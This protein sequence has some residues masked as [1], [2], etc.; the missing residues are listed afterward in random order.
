[1]PGADGLPP[2]SYARQVATPISPIDRADGEVRGG[3]GAAPPTSL[4]TQGDLLPNGDGVP[5][6][7]AVKAPRPRPPHR[8]R[9]GRP[10]RDGWRGWIA[11]VAASLRSFG[12]EE[13]AQN[14]TSCGQT[15]R[16]TP[17]RDVADGGCG[18]PYGRVEVRISCDARVCPWCSRRAAQ[19]RVELV[20]AAAMRVPDYQAAQ[21]AA[22]VE[23]L[24]E[25]EHQAQRA[26]AHW[27]AF[28]V[29]AA[30]RAERR[31]SQRERER[32]EAKARRHRERAEKAGRRVQLAR[33]Q[34]AGVRELHRWGWKLVTISPLWNPADA[35][36]Y[37][38]A[39]M[40]ARAEDVLRRWSK[41]WEAGARAG[42]LA[43]AT[44]RTEMSAHGHIHVHVLYR[45]PWVPQEWWQSEAGCIVDVRAIRAKDAR[46]V[47]RE[48]KR[49]EESAAAYA[50]RV[51]RGAVTEAVKYALKTPTPTSAEWMSGD[52]RDVAHPEL[53][54]RWMLAT[55]HMQLIRHYGVMADAIAAEVEMQEPPEERPA[56]SRCASCG[57]ELHTEASTM[58]PTARVARALGA[59]WK[60]P[61]KVSP[62][63][64]PLPKRVQIVRVI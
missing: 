22:T 7:G 6:S 8:H 3:W 9:L 23:R 61:P 28:A 5:A 19:E 2:S 30:N 13:M 43:A 42:G 26:V 60:A 39:T 4:D 24:Q 45:G 33:R 49:A 46:G 21:L 41:V 55:R 47:E 20:T 38:P 16:V 34:L 27:A 15:A 1:M 62:W 12:A 63:G 18:D 10:V 32:D 37:E 54:A 25:Q 50:E 14:L 53:A 52:R 56:D 59:A 29:E 51:L 17:C 31:H 57:G 40:R 58:H 36:E 48:A 11:R 64:V 35:A 44:V